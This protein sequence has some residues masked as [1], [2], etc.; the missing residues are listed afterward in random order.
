MFLPGR[1]LFAVFSK[2][3]KRVINSLE[4]S[5]E[6]VF[7]T[8]RVEK[9][10]SYLKDEITLEIYNLGQNEY[11]TIK[12]F[13]TLS[14]YCGR[15]DASGKIIKILVA[16]QSI[17]FVSKDRSDLD[18]PKT[19]IICS[20]R[21]RRRE[22][23]NLNVN[24]GVSLFNAINFI[25][26]RA[27]MNC[28]ISGELKN[29]LLS[30]PINVD[31]VANVLNRIKR[32]YKFVHISN[33]GGGQ[34]YDLYFSLYR[35]QSEQKSLVF[36]PESGTLINEWV[37]IESNGDISFTSL[38]NVIPYKIGDRILVAG[39]YFNK[40]VRSYQDYKDS[41][42]ITKRLEK[43]NHFESED[44]ILFEYVI[45]A[46]SYN[47]DIKGSFNV[48]IKGRPLTKLAGVSYGK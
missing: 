14:L 18:T 30:K 36:S 2:Q 42:K 29:Y 48:V 34:D 43:T 8:A 22:T 4:I 26:K 38:A 20:A 17:L 32:D 6:K 28:F 25:C 33:D 1:F 40:S 23:N 46:L 24:A 13:D 16:V 7:F 21:V 44:S 45:V 31:N 12:T 19:I 47:L 41:I 27:A 5:S 37:S 15:R 35:S 9:Y 39:K 10:L 11:E 3:E